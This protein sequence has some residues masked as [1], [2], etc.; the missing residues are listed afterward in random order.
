MGTSRSTCV[1]S[2]AT[3]W[4][5]AAKTLLL[6]SLEPY[7]IMANK[8]QAGVLAALEGGLVFKGRVKGERR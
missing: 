3:A 7:T 8:D 6:K 2:A 1:F 5:Q 4:A